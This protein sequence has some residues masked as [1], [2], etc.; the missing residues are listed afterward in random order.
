[1]FKLLLQSFTYGDDTFHQLN[2]QSPLLDRRKFLSGNIAL[3]MNN[4]ITGEEIMDTFII[5]IYE[6]RI[7]FATTFKYC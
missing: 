1:M 2:S 6:I 4:T 7:L 5:E 3:K